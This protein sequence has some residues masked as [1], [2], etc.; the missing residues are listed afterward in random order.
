M[1]VTD[2]IMNSNLVR[3]MQF[4][5]LRMMN[6]QTQAAT[7]R[8]INDFADDPAGLGMVRRYEAMLQ[9]NT[10]FQRNVTRGRTIVDATDT[11]LQ[12]MND[13]A[14]RA[15]EL[16]LGQ[17]TGTAT[18]STMG[19]AA[20]EV[21]SIIDEMLALANSQ[22][23]GSYIF[24][25]QR[26]NVSPFVMS[27]TGEV[28][29]QGDD[30]DMTSRIGPN[31]E[32]VL[33]VPG[34]ELLGYSMAQLV[35][36]ADLSP[37]LVG[38]DRLDDINGGAGWTP[39]AIMVTDSSGMAKI[40]NI[41]GAGTV[42][43]ILTILNTS[44]LSASITPDGS[45]IQVVDPGGGPLTLTDLGSGRAA[46]TLGIAGSSNS[47]TING[48]D[49]RTVPMAGTTLAAIPSLNGSLPLGSI[50][51]ESGGV[52]VVIDLSSATD[53]GDIESIFEAEVTAGGLP[54]MDMTF[55]PGGLRVTSSVSTPFTIRDDITGGTATLLGIAG[56]G[57]A[58]DVFR[59]LE[60]LK[61]S[62]EAHDQEG[63][64]SA[65][66]AL[67]SAQ[68][69]LRGLNVVA[70]G[71]STMLDWA[72]TTLSDRGLELQTSL[73]MIRDADLTRVA[74]DL[75]QAETAYQASLAVS[76]TLMR[77]SLFDYL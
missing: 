17:S 60:N 57:G 33:N 39:G 74:T 25:G 55:G 35:G 13:A 52:Q 61:E 22:V 62:L 10:Q 63:V 36:A 46:E 37:N 24:A 12:A 64:R 75:S 8:R 5:Q 76:S 66:F 38:S 28:V 68:D 42:Q 56:D 21:Q 30:G 1:R 31:S 58:N 16:A 11:A 18:N 41:T 29:Y 34:N 20:L 59:G 51:V 50:I 3:R 73:S 54:A 65:M 14:V 67:Q 6:L 9:Q 7:T 27:A 53:L 49:I 40:L 72:D 47:G 77:M 32:L 4:S 69:H 48:S 2:N 43:D 15:T 71:K 23:D 44:G 70:G 19:F 26:T 45:G